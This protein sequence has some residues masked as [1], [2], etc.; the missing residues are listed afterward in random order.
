MSKQFASG[1]NAFGF[2]DVCNFRFKLTAL[3]NQVVNKKTTNIMA[4][5]TCY[6]VDHPQLWIGQV[7]KSD[8]QALRKP[9]PDPS[10]EASREL[11]P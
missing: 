1:K 7:D 11:I 2:C 6:D 3:R 8:P 10:L 5:P 9:R 4:C